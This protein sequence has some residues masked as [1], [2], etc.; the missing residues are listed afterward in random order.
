MNKNKDWTIRIP[1]KEELDNFFFNEDTD[2][3]EL[4]SNGDWQIT[5]YVSAETDESGKLKNITGCVELYNKRL[6]DDKNIEKYGELLCEKIFECFCHS[7]GYLPI[8]ELRWK[9]PSLVEE[10]INYIDYIKD[11]V[12]ELIY[13]EKRTN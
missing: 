8:D 7:S 6:Y 9:L 11:T 4:A 12:K 10:C 2:E 5:L 1:N 13:A 3:L